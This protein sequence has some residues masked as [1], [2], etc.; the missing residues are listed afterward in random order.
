M[1]SDIHID[2]ALALIKDFA[3]IKGLQSTSNPQ[4]K[5][6]GLQTAEQTIQ[7]LYPPS[8]TLYP[9]CLPVLKRGERVYPPLYPPYAKKGRKSVPALFL[10]MGEGGG[11]K[12]VRCTLSP[13]CRGKRKLFLNSKLFYGTV[14]LECTLQLCI[15]IIL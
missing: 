7:I 9:P 13:L 2:S 11:G 12:S 4:R 10:S 5:N 14:F 6:G 15:I 8:H 3:E 1:L